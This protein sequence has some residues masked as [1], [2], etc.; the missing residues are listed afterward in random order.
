MTP[1]VVEL[2]M[3]LVNPLNGTHGHW[4]V[5]SRLRKQQR[6]TISLVM[7]AHIRIAGIVPP[8][9]V[10]V[11]RIAPRA[12]DRHDGLPASAKAV[13][14]GIS[15]AMGIRDDDARVE[16]RIEQ[17]RGRPKQ[18]AVEIRVESFP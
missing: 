6:S 16:W 15:D 14:D 18:Y 9:R 3:R 2:P 5:K 17:R 8:C 4:A 11:T 13:V 7:G 10:T 1:L 12:L